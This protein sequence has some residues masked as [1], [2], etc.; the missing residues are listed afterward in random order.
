MT[1]VICRRAPVKAAG[2]IS[3]VAPPIIASPGKQPVKIGY[4]NPLTGYPQGD[5][6]NIFT[7]HNL[8]PGETAAG[9]VADTGCKTQ[10]PSI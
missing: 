1:S 6:T 7:M 2:A 9:A 4:V 8:V 5:P 3:L 10:M